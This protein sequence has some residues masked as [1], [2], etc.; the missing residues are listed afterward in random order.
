MIAKK[1][2]K[3][4]NLLLYRNQ[5]KFYVPKF[6]VIFK[7]ELNNK[8][9]LQNKI[10]RKFKKNDKLII[11]S[12]SLNEDNKKQSNAGKYL[13]ILNVKN[14]END[15]F[16]ALKKVG[17]YLE[18]GDQIIIQLFISKVDISGVIFTRD[19]KNYSP[20][21]VINYD[22]SKKTDLI[23]SGKLNPSIKT[24]II[25][26]DKKTS[27]KFSILISV[28]KKIEKLFKSDSLDIEFAIKNRKIYI[29]QS[30]NLIIKNKL[31][32]DYEIG[33]ALNNL[34]KKIIKL[35]KNNPFL[36]GK[37]TFFS[38]MADWNPA[39]M[40]GTKPNPLAISLYSELITN[41]TWA[42]QRKNYGYKNVIPN[43]LMVNFAG[44]PF[45]DLRTDLNS[46]LPDNLKINV[47][48]NI[49]DNCMLQIKKT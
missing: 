32:L 21:Y 6:L 44:S 34:K 29:F 20:Y 3:A 24:K 49:I 7:S 9:K 45:I 13:S 48:N 27:D 28:I 18:S 43:P 22:T 40:I 39:E 11:R 2:S 38:N 31:N 14:S 41:E 23:T 19:P 25:Y 16:K 35:K 26:R 10:K 46:F 17:S 4:N 36:S 1:S 12:S 47:Q 8:H 33:I 15:V 5:S 37:T 42:I 30:R